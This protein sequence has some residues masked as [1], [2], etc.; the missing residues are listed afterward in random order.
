MS[1]TDDTPVKKQTTI[2]LVLEGVNDIKATLAIVER[3][4]DS[5][6]NLAFRAHEK[7]KTAMWMRQSWGPYVVAALALAVSLSTAAFAIAS[8]AK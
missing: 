1:A 6:L 8:V 2:E 5:A 3:R 4:T 7:A